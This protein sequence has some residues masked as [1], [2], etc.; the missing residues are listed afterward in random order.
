MGKTLSGKVALVTGGSRGI[1]AAIVRRLATDGATVVFTYSASPGSAND[2]AR[3]IE[4]T[5][6]QVLAIHADSAQP[7]AVKAAVAETVERFGRIDILVNNA[8]ILTRGLVDD[9]SL[10]DFDRMFAINVRAVFVGVQSV[11]PH[12]RNGGR[13]IMTGSI[14]S[15]RRRLPRRVCLRDDQ[16]RGRVHDERSSARLG[17][18]RHHRQR[19]CA[20]PNRDGYDRRP[21]RAGDRPPSDVARAPRHGPRGCQPG[22]LSG[23]TRRW[24]RH[25]SLADDRRRL[26]RLIACESQCPAVDGVGIGCGHTVRKALVGFELCRSSATWPTAVPSRVRHDLVV[27]AG[28]YG[29]GDDDLLQVFR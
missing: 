28:D 4:A 2:L 25:R 14:V 19:D 22:R 21:G 12:M 18:T 17:T 8:G 23:G 5:G 15:E 10:E 29:H 27:I 26:S 1:G 20:R 11:L 16:R 24:L 6:A 9:Y 13:I 3:E 7:A